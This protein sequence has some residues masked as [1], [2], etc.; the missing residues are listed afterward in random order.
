[1]TRPDIPMRSFDESLPMALLAARETAMQLFRPMLAAHEL[2]E[3]QWR[4]LRALS[5]S[6]S[7]IEVG[8]LAERTTLLAPSLSRILTNL[9]SR[10]LITREPVAT[11]QRRANI[12]L[13]P[14]GHDLVR[15]VAPSS[16]ARYNLIEEQ[17]GAA[18]LHQLLRELHDLAALDID[19]T[20]TPIEAT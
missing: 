18:R 11:D 7:P 5:A 15:R 1:M 4:V 2:T 16:E 10:D 9:E 12:A 14:A 17:F 20:E 3:Q 19:P 13:T 6:E 8:P